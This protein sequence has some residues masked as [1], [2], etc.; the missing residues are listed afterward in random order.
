M[1][2]FSNKSK[3]QQAQTLLAFLNRCRGVSCQQEELA[4]I[5]LQHNRLTSTDMCQM[6]V[7]DFQNAFTLS[8]NTYYLRPLS[9][10]EDREFVKSSDSEILENNFSFLYYTQLHPKLMTF[11]DPYPDISKVLTCE[12]VWEGEDDQPPLYNEVVIDPQ[13]QPYNIAAILMEHKQAKFDLDKFLI[14]TIK[15]LIALIVG[16]VKVYQFDKKAPLS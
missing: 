15:D 13:E 1:S 6:L 10:I 7:L 9:E 11:K 8:R 4:N 14:P 12:C 16:E 2:S 5:H 3:Y